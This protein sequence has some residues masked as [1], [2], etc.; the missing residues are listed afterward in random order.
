MPGG[1]TFTVPKSIEVPNNWAPK[2]SATT[3]WVDL[4]GGHFVCPELDEA[5]P[6]KTGVLS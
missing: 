4:A 3:R 6:T 2:P 5:R 1:A